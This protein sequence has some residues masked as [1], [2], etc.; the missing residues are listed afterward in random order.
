LK[1]VP[2]IIFIFHFIGAFFIQ[3]GEREA[4]QEIEEN[5]IKNLIGKIRK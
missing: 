3:K 4:G 1:N 5:L 2:R